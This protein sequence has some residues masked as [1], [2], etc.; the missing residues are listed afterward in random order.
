MFFKFLTCGLSLI[1]LSLFSTHLFADDAAGRWRGSWSSGNTGH[2]GPLRATIRET[3][4]GSYKAL[5]VG[6]FAG[7]IPFAYRADLHPLPGSPGTYASVKR[8]PLLGN[9]HMHA[10][11][12][13]SVFHA[14]FRGKQDVGVFQMHRR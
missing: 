12:A 14:T 1:A 9:Y 3:P 7:V 8:L 13:D 5:F 2:R 4:N 11:V 6:R 10:T